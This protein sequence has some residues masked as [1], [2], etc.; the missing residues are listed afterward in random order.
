MGF[1]VHAFSP[2]VVL[3]FPRGVFEL[4]KARHKLDLVDYVTY[5]PYTPNPDTCYPM[6]EA[7]RQ[8]VQS[9]DPKIKLYQGEC[10]CPSILEWGH[11]LNSYPWTE[12][13]QPKW[14]LRRMAG[15]RA[16]NIPSSVFTMIDLRYPTMLQSFGLIRADLQHRIIYKRPSFYAVQHMVSFFDDTVVPHGER[17]YES[18]AGR[19]MAIAVFKKQRST[20]VLIWYKDRIPTDNLKWDAVDVEMEG[21]TFTDP[22]CVEMISGKVYVIDKSNWADTK[23]STQF[24]RLPVWDSPIMIAE[25]S[26]IELRR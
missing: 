5:H 12:Y 10:G 11:A 4:L 8:L 19:K 15:D 14:V 1:S 23:D 16:R 20:A 22:V 6:V 26:L 9:Y 3:E 17:E 25:R 7:L 24:G 13:S 18:P 2:N 21:V